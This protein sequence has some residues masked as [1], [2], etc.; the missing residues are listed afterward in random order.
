MASVRQSAHRAAH[1]AKTANS[2]SSHN[3]QK[4]TAN[5]A[6]TNM[7][8]HI[9]P[10]W[11]FLV[12]FV[13]MAAI[14]STLIP[15][16]GGFDEPS[17]IARVEQLAHGGILAQP[18]DRSDVNWTYSDDMKTQDQLY[19]GQS[20]YAL[21][22]TAVR[23]M[24]DMHLTK[25]PYAFPTWS[26]DR[27]ASNGNYGDKTMTFV[28]SN[29]AVNSPVSYIPQLIG[30]FIARLFTA[31]AQGIIIIMRLF[32]D[33]ALGAALFFCIRYIP[34]GKW[35]LTVVALTP[36]TLITCGMVTA[37][38][39][40]LICCT[41]FIT[42]VL[43]ALVS[44]R[45]GISRLNWLA[46]SGIGC[47]LGI[48]KLTYL[49]LILL[50]ALLPLMRREYRNLKHYLA[51]GGIFLVAII[52]FLLWYRAIGGINTGAMYSAAVHPDDQKHLVLT[53]P[54]HYL[55]LLIFS[56]MGQN[57]FQ[58]GASSVLI[59]HSNGLLGN[60]WPIVL[61][62]MAAVMVQDPREK[63]AFTTRRAWWTVAAFVAEFGMIFVL[64]ATALYLQFTPVGQDSISG[65]QP[66]Y[67]APILMLL[68]LPM[69][70]IRQQ[71]WR[72]QVPA[73]R[74]TCGEQNE[75]AELAEHSEL[76]TQPVSAPASDD[77]VLPK[78]HS[79]EVFIGMNQTSERIMVWTMIVLEVFSCGYFLIDFVRIMF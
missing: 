23:N 33:L 78:T 4:L 68:V 38:T 50:L 67:Y 12:L 63:S 34:I 18:I 43:C 76:L 48:I 66:R 30:F 32:G 56:F 5:N 24:R 45:G 37:D 65:L 22:S 59:A 44:D 41:G 25:D 26:T 40:T 60:G 7:Q 57:F 58:I 64:I 13:L 9:R 16:G 42:A 35:A 3:T 8:H 69:L 47:L 55:K 14:F 70:I 21:L 2:S 11:V 72:T 29:S 75:Q 27:I 79:D 10:E 36:G 54:L 17:H 1:G 20:D 39:M 61:L 62:F 73:N 77:S 49:P 52:L 28:F 19:G 6:A 46:L 53:Q 31:D 15:A 74:I 51:L 71:I